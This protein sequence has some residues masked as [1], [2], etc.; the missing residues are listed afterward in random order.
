[1]TGHDLLANV[2]IGK[3]LLK[4]A[5]PAI[6][7]TLINVIYN[8][9]DTYFIGLLRDTAM[10]S[11]VSFT[12]PV[13]WLCSAFTGIITN[14]A[15]QLISM[16]A[17][18]GDHEGAGR[19]RSFAVYATL[20]MSLVIS[21]LYALILRPMLS[22]AGADGASLEYG[23]RYLIVVVLA[24]PLTNVSVAMQSV[25]R[26]DGQSVKASV[27]SIA[28]I[29]TNII[30]DPILILAFRLD[31]LGAALATAAGG[32]VSLIIG[33]V[34]T[35]GQFSVKLMKIPA[36]DLRK[37]VAL[38]LPN[39]IT[40]VINCA[41]MFVGFKMGSTAGGDGLIA[42]ISVGSKVYSFAVSLIAAFAFSLQPFV[43]Y[44]YA[45]GDR[46]RLRKGVKA[47]VIVGTTFS[48]V[49]MAISL[50]FGNK[51]I[52][53]FSDD[54]A[55]LMYGTRMLRCL[56]AGIPV[57]MP[58]MTCQM[59]LSSTGSAKKSL[60]AGLSRQ[61]LIFA[62]VLAILY[63]LIGIEGLFY[64]YPISDILACALSAALVFKPEEKKAR[65]PA[66]AVIE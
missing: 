54:A 57:M 17:G 50:A 43:G 21:P 29:V 28:G 38:S 30:L 26:S 56:S 3:T 48:I 35:R 31:M 40:T 51:L 41:I 27:A 66:N 52:G 11:G 33:T 53:L 59:Y 22:F 7:T 36:S 65:I 2:R 34:Y 39:T 58:L 18:K 45:S 5:I 25:L 15:P 62:P 8:M 16:Y 47:A 13:M 37:T 23:Y 9:T 12:M 10:L 61:V 42:S 24:M 46:T 4:L 44:N 1:M 14:G 32:V 55:V 19:M 64:A 49:F 6:L 63:S 20:L 60:V